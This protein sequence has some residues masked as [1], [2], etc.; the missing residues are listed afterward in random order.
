MV[1]TTEV[2]RTFR[3]TCP[4]HQFFIF[5]AKFNRFNNLSVKFC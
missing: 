2:F 3:K 5:A 4:G 1:S